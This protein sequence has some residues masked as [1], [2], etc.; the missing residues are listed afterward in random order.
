MLVEI[1]CQISFSVKKQELMRRLLYPWF[2]PETSILWKP[3]K[4]EIYRKWEALYE[5]DVTPFD[6]DFYF[7]L[8]K[9]S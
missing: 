8:D 5:R 2:Q 6:D 4:Y 1:Q 9:Y 7:Y 3:M